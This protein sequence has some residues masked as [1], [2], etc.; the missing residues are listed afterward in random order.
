M[1]LLSNQQSQTKDISFTIREDNEKQHSL[2]FMK[3]QSANPWNFFLKNEW[4][5]N[6]KLCFFL[7]IN[8]L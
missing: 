5:Q 3:L 4:K 6:K 8:L 7:S 1:L 2:P